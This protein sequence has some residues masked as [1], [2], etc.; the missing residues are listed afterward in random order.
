MCKKNQFWHP[1]RTLSGYC[2]LP[3]WTREVTLHQEWERERWHTPSV[4]RVSAGPRGVLTCSGLHLSASGLNRFISFSRPL[5]HGDSAGRRRKLLQKRSEW[6]KVAEFRGVNDELL[7]IKWKETWRG[8][9]VRG[10]PASDPTPHGSQYLHSTRQAWNYTENGIVMNGPSNLS[11]QSLPQK[12]KR[13]HR[14]IMWAT[15]GKRGC[16]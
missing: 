3:E 6:K 10:A 13:S 7:F 8:A 2:R 4:V 11:V 12:A 9:G 15:T 1:N 14:H 16:F 5:Y